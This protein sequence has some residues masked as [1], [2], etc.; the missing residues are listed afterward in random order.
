MNQGSIRRWHRRTGILLAPF[1]LLQTV[2]GLVLTYGVFS[3]ITAT[4][5]ENAP[6]AVKTTWNVMMAKMHYGPGLIG[7]IYHSL[8]GLG[9]V[10]LIISGVWIWVDFQRKAKQAKS[11]Q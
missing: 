8:I 3:Q 4:L 6:A 1:L 5:S 10:W 7:W 2:S 9:L 11:Q